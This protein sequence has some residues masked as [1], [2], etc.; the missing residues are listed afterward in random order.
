MAQV[1]QV[2]DVEAQGV[3]VVVHGAPQVVGAAVVPSAL[4]SMGGNDVRFG[5]THLEV[6]SAPRRRTGPM[7]TT[8]AAQRRDRAEV[9]YD[10]SLAACPSR[11]LL[12]RVSDK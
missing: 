4:H 2:E 8:T 5:S 12:D 3:E 1:D 6:R 11:Q 7:A 10:A 9:E